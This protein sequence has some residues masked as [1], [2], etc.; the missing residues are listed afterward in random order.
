MIPV[1]TSSRS[2]GLDTQQS[3]NTT[4]EQELVPTAICGFLISTLSVVE[5]SVLTS[6]Q[7]LG[8]FPRTGSASPLD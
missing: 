4:D 5:I 7:S 2:S 1:G 6:S 8:L 3:E